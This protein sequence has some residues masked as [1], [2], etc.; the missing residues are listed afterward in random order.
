MAL[1]LRGSID[2]FHKA[3]TV[4]FRALIKAPKKFLM[5]ADGTYSK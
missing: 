1:G 3:T 5:E 4:F 2:G